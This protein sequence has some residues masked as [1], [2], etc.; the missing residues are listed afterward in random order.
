MITASGAAFVIFE[1][2]DGF[3]EMY[4]M[5]A[6]LAP[7]HQAHQR[8]LTINKRNL[9]N[10]AFYCSLT[11]DATV[12]RVQRLLFFALQTVCEVYCVRFVRIPDLF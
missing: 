3:F 2:L 6:N 9:P 12:Q 7:N 4:A 1:I 8:L 10:S 11:P 5:T